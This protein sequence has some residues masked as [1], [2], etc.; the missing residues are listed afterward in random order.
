MGKT[1]AVSNLKGGVGKT[2]TAASLSIGLARQG[3]KTL[4]VD[5]DSQHSLTVS[6]GVSEPQ[7]LTNT[8]ASAMMSVIDEEEFEPVAGIIRHSEGA[9]LLP[10]NM[11]LTKVELALVQ[12]MERET[13]LRR[14]IEKLK[15]SYDYIIFD[16]PPTLGLLTLNALAA[17]DSIIVPVCPKY[18]DAKG[19][20]LLLKSIAQM[21]R[22]IN[23]ALAIDGILLTMI[24]RRAKL[25][26]EV[27]ASI[28]NA[29]GSNIRIFSESV[30]RSVRAAETSGLGMSIFAHD[31]NGQV[32][33]A[34]AA[35]VE[36]VLCCG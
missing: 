23:P 28:E 35:L 7:K 13:V 10:S 19:M 16:C 21:R 32:A 2:M 34:Y 5:C 26:R 36:G 27:I 20:E 29:Y 30:P 25:T 1:I 12:T 4:A 11:R 24:D 15:P 8:L 6:F 33:A 31:P 3:K 22:S 18:L 14:Y 17:A 9:D